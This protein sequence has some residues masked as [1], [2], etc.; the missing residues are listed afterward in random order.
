MKALEFNSRRYIGIGGR[1][2]DRRLQDGGACHP[3]TG[4][5][6][7]GARTTQEG[8]LRSSVFYRATAAYV[9]RSR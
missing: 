1:F 8:R 7:Q 4:R 3:I 2:D 6:T 5:N 9:L